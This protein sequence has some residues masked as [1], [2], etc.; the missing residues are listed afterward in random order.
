MDNWFLYWNVEVWS[1][2]VCTYRAKGCHFASKVKK[3]FGMLFCEVIE[4]CL[5]VHLSKRKR[6]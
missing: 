5:Y 6:M 2:S 3:I 4:L 1:L